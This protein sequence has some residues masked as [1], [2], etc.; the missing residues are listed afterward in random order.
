M[1]PSWRIVEKEGDILFWVTI[2]GMI[3]GAI[4]GYYYGNPRWLDAIGGAG[5]FGFIFAAIGILLFWPLF[6]LIS[7]IRHIVSRK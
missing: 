3:I 2:I 1:E 5:I 4:I 7:T 6:Y